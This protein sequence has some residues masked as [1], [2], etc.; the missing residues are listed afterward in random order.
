MS[1]EESDDEV[2]RPT[3]NKKVKTPSIKSIPGGLFEDHESTLDSTD[4]GPGGVWLGPNRWVLL[5]KDVV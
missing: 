4:L 2:P 1:E 5:G 3:S